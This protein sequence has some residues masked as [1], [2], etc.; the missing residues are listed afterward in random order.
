[1][2]YELD[3][4]GEWVQFI[5]IHR[6]ADSGGI[7]SNPI[8]IVLH[9]TAG[10]NRAADIQT[11]TALDDVY[12]SAHFHVSRDGVLT[13]LV[14]LNRRAYHAGNSTW[15]GRRYLNSCTIGIEIG[16][17]GPLVKR[18]GL[19]YA[20]PRNFTKVV[21]PE[22]LVYHGRHR[23]SYVTYEHWERFRAAQYAVLC[24]LLDCLITA[25]PS[26]RWL[27][28]HDDIAPGRKIDPGPAFEMGALRQM[29]HERLSPMPEVQR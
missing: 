12:V 17:W 1:M 23:N 6:A 28:G 8:G 16:N 4:K 9:Y 22:L 21:V 29:F 18:D 26:I 3:E 10:A 20:W 27:L 19:Y 11:L 13:A 14:P 24:P 25:F 5:P 7:L 2:K 15:Q